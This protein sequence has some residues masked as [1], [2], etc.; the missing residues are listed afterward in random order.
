MAHVSRAGPAEALHAHGTAQCSGR[1]QAA[2]RTAT[3]GS[4]SV[5][6]F[7]ELNPTDY[8]IKGHGSL[9]V[10]AVSITGQIVDEVEC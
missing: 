10:E 9:K 7:G 4:C 5:Q 1:Y 3:S 2:R 6:W 8:R